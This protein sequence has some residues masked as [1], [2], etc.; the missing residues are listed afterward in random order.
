LTEVFAT[1]TRDEWCA[2]LEHT[3]ACF[4]PVLTMAEAAEH[5]HNRERETF[6]D[7]N[8]VVQPAPAPRFSRT[9]PLVVLPPARPGENTREVLADWGFDS[10]TINSLFEAG[11]V[12]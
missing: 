5:P 1:K 12:K 11:A 7:F 2:V 9:Q 4:A 3:D 8:G 10:L 6:I